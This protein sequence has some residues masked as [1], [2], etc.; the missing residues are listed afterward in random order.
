MDIKPLAHGVRVSRKYY[1]LDSSGKAVREL[2]SGEPIARGSYIESVVEAENQ[3]ETSI[4]YV[5]VENPRPS[6]CEV[7]PENDRRF[8]RVSTAF[9]LREDRIPGVAYHHERTGKTI[10][11]RCVLH[12]ELSGEFLVP[13]ARV[14]LMYRTLTRGHS[15][16]FQL[17]VQ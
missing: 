17:V 13:P 1:L 5:L 10:T 7:L 12:A 14:E 4:Q 8:Q 3:S 9:A 2:K 6:S 15:T 16:P 11:D